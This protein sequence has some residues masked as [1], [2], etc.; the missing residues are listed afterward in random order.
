MAFLLIGKKEI[1]AFI[2]GNSHVLGNMDVARKFQLIKNK[3]FN[4]RKQQRSRQQAELK[5]LMT[6]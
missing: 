5:K 4:E 2:H 3:I 6:Y 1:E